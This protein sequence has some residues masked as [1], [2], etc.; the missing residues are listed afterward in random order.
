MIIREQRNEQDYVCDIEVFMFTKLLG[1]YLLVFGNLELALENTIEIMINKIVQGREIELRK[2][3]RFL[4]KGQS[5]S[6]KLNVLKFLILYLESKTQA[7]WLNFIQNVQYLSE[8]RNILAHGMYGEESDNL[9]KLSYDNNGELKETSMSI[10]KLNELLNQ[11]GERYRQL[12]DSV[13][14]PLELYICEHPKLEI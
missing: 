12:F 8:I 2:I 13:I 4:L 7:E 6:K 3:T 1:E 11:L 9:L 5:V 10:E 14:E